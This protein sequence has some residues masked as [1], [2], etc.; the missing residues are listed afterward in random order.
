MVMQRVPG[1]RIECDLGCR[2]MVMRMMFVMLDLAMCAAQH[3][4]HRWRDYAQQD[5]K[6]PEPGTDFLT[7]TDKHG[8]SARRQKGRSFNARSAQRRHL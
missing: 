5:G 4:R 7:V 2:S 3:L 8:E 1:V 6:Y